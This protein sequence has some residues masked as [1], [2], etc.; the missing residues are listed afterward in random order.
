MYLRTYALSAKYTTEG[1]VF[2][3]RFAFWIFWLNRGC[4][5]AHFCFNIIVKLIQVS[6]YRMRKNYSRQFGNSF[7]W[8]C[9]SKPSSSAIGTCILHNFCFNFS[10]LFYL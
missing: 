10:L 7:L 8:S 9:L 4:L 3:A 5:G 2:W 1:A 6:K